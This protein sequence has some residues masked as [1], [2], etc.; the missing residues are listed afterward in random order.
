MALI[1]ISALVSI[2]TNQAYQIAAGLIAGEALLAGGLCYIKSSD[3][4]VYQAN[5][6]AANEAAEY[7]GFCPR[8]VAAG[9]PVTLFGPFTRI[10]YS[11][12]ALTPGDFYYCGA[13]AGRLDAATTTGD[14]VGVAMA[15]TS[16]DIVVMRTKL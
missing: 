12:A 11:D 3:G 1:A 5:G 4:L 2:D 16:S 7:V 13:T 8:A 10:K 9:Q 6:T 15:L 14:T